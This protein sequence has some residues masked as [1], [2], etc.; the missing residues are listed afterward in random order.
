[1]KKP[2]EKGQKAAPIEKESDAELIARLS[3]VTFHT[4]KEAYG[5]LF[6]IFL[7]C[8]LDESIRRGIVNSARLNIAG[9][10]IPVVTAAP[11]A[12]TIPVTVGNPATL[13][14]TVTSLNRIAPLVGIPPVT[15]GTLATISASF[16][17]PIPICH[18]S[19]CAMPLQSMIPMDSVKLSSLSGHWR[20]I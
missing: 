9:H 6:T 12:L 14:V 5:L 19:R 16:P 10:G 11:F 15:A 4:D 7:T 2:K 20:L 18:S 1:M 13:T 3:Q 17:M 8:F